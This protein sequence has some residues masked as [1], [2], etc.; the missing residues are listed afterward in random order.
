MQTPSKNFHVPLPQ[1]LYL[2][3]KKESERAQKPATEI[4]RNAIDSW[5]KE[6]EK[7]ALHQAIFEY[8]TENAGTPNDLDEE[9]EASTVKFLKE[10]E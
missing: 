7:E 6:R 8:A 4:A 2:K 9:L 10:E 3:L 1:D 5:L